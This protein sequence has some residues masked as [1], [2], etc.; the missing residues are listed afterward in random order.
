MKNLICAV[1]VLAVSSAQAAT[2]HVDTTN[3][4]GPG[5]GSEADPYCSIQTA[6]DNAVDTDEIVVAPGTY[7]ETI[8]LLGKA[9]W[10][11]SSDGPEV[12]IIN[13]LASGTVVTANSGEGP[14]TTVEGFTL[15][16]GVAAASSGFTVGGG[17]DIAFSDLTVRDCI[18]LGNVAVFGGG[19]NIEGGSP[20]IVGCLFVGNHGGTGGGGLSAFASSPTVIGCRFVGNSSSSDGGGMWLGGGENFV[21]GCT[22]LQNTA[23]GSGGGLLNANGNSTVVNCLFADNTSGFRGG[24]VGDLASTGV[25]NL[26]N[27]T[28]TQNESQFGG[29]MGNSGGAVRYVSNCVFW[30]NS[31]DGGM[32]ETA[33]IEPEDTEIVVSYSCVQG[34]WS[35]AGPLS[36]RREHVAVYEP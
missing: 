18:V 26:V 19:M 15:M 10:L 4:P 21:A 11:H 29:G 2:I 5:D 16:G 35:G 12:T 27:C 28:V 31:D 24:G 22:F 8:N 20:V 34:G 30:A 14:G 3:C 6:I 1:T 17:M 25:L 32:D 7:V 23:V 36:W 13:A 9:I 33:Q